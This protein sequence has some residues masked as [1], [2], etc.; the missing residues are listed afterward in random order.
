M[1]SFLLF[2]ALMLTVSTTW[3]GQKT[4]VTLK[5]PAGDDNGTGLLIYPQRRDFETGD[6]DL[7][8]L[9]ISRDEEGFWFEATFKNPI[10][11]P[12]SVPSSVGADSLANFARKGFYQFNIDIYVD[13]DR[14]KGSGD[15]N[16]LPG[17]RVTIDP[18]YAWEKA[19][20]LTPRPELMRHQLLDALT[21]Q[22]PDRTSADIETSVGQSIF[23]PTRIKVRGKSIFFFVPAG[24]FS[25]SDGTDWA[26][27]ALVTGASTTI[28]AD[29]T[30]SSNTTNK[31]ME[32]LTLGVM[33]P[34]V[35]HP[36]DTFGYSGIK[37]S[38][39]V[40]LLGATAEQQ[41]RQLAAKTNLTGVAWG[42]HAIDGAMP[43]AAAANNVPATA[44]GTNAS[45]VVP[46]GKLLQ[47][48][49][50][51]ITPQA[52]A[53]AQAGTLAEP[54]IS[55]RL[56]TLQQLLDQKLIDEN[57]YKQQKQRILKEI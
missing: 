45:T 54:S 47:P 57:E 29:F 56:Q 44:V 7:L 32:S 2:I 18:S 4:L 26:I 49:S 37:P 3:A 34:A 9:Q 51:A 31:P 50:L 20:I 46:V 53:P 5:D 55:K 12:D 39:V 38:P 1:K 28:S 30:L 42:P 43:V 33:Q 27:T 19:V 24:F 13:T 22:Y 52:S 40:D 16:T 8:Q 35:G 23:F 48:E 25:G 17:R 15:T 11:D 21:E 41:K 6:L 14:V 10:R 36:R